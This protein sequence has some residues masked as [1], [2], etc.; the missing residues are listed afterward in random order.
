LEVKEIEVF[1]ITDFTKF[2]LREKTRL[3]ELQ[4]EHNL[5][6][7]DR[8]GP[9]EVA[10]GHLLS[11]LTSALQPAPGFGSVIVSDFQQIF[12]EFHGKLLSLL[13]WGGVDC[14]DARDIHGRCDGHA[15]ALT[16]IE[17]IE[18]NIFGELM[19]LTW[20]SGEGW[21]GDSSLNSF[22]FTLK[23]PQNVPAQRFALK[24]QE[25]CQALF[26][27]S[28]SGPQFRDIFLW[29]ITTQTPGIQVSLTGLTL[30]TPNCTMGLFSWV[31]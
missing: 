5:L 31:L 15:N 11:A 3:N 22:L 13:W 4:A 18:R 20:C 24:I 8:I 30:T 10:V 19:A 12:A 26:C 14:F 28:D 21:H 25:K 7:H 2:E 23:N 9:L 16:L 17:D 1:E 6:K 29:I 27:C